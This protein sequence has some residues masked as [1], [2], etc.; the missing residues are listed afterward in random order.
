MLQNGK[1]LVI[2]LMLHLKPLMIQIW[3]GLYE[4]NPCCAQCHGATRESSLVDYFLYFTAS[5][6][7]SLFCQTIER[8][9]HTRGYVVKSWD[10]CNVKKEKKRE[11]LYFGPDQRKCTEGPTWCEYTLNYYKNTGKKLEF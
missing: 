8:T 5:P 4:T 11:T 7:L 2:N 6:G 3:L 9:L 1:H 10:S